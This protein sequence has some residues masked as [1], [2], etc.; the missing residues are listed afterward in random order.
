MR[1]ARTI[2]SQSQRQELATR[3]A[4]A[5]A[6][7]SLLSFDSNGNVCMLCGEPLPGRTARPVP[8]SLLRSDCGARSSPTG[9]S[10]EDLALPAAAFLQTSGH[11]TTNGFCEL[12][13]AKSCADAIAIKDYLYWPKSLDLAN[14]ALR[15]NTAW[16]G[17]YCRLNGFLDSKV[18]ALQRNFTGLQHL[19]DELC[20]TKYAKHGIEKLS[21][22][23]MMASSRKADEK[24]GPS[25]LEA[26]RLA[27]WNCAMGD[28]GCDLAMCSYSF[29]SLQGEGTG[30]Y[31]EC[32]G[33][34]PVEGMPF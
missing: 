10:R 25:L 14:P 13:F 9:P 18:V 32:A 34:H 6:E 28:L 30:L 26:E 12:N 2:A 3:D 24:D 20:R 19:A 33:W 15:E 1:P 16:D 23:D 8:R 29:C 21:F 22:M 27:A 5:R 31:G 4:D 7:S 11:R 17:R